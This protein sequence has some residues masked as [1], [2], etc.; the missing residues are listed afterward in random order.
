MLRNGCRAT[1]YEFLKKRGV[2]LKDLPDPKN[3]K[4]GCTV[5]LTQ[6]KKHKL[7]PAPDAVFTVCSGLL[8]RTRGPVA[9][10]GGVSRVWD[11][12]QNSR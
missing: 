5:P 11:M 7:L 9:L 2:E 6:K 8:S 10:C 3:E 12:Y 1:L 4:P